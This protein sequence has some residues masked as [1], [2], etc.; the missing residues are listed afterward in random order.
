M[1]EKR[2]MRIV[3]GK[4]YDTD[5]A[6]LL[7][8]GV[9]FDGGANAPGRDMCLYRTPNGRYFTVSWSIWQD[10]RDVLTPVTEEEARALYEGPLRLHSASY[11]EAFPDIEIEDA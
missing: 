6:Q 5:K 4:R 10:V 9:Y 1:G 2:M 7:A 3:G 8:K 11:E